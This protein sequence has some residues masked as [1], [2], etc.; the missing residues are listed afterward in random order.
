MTIGQRLRKFGLERYGSI[1]EFAKA[2][3]MSPPG[4][5]QY[6]ADKREPGTPV[7][8]RLIRVGCDVEWLMT[9]KAIAGQATGAV[10]EEGEVYKAGSQGKGARFI[11]RM[12]VTL[13]GKETLDSK[14]FR[15]GAGVP[16]F[17]DTC[18][19]LEV[20]G[21]LLVDAEPIA[22]QPGSICVFE[23]GKQPRLGSVV[24]V[25]LKDG[26]RLVRVVSRSSKVAMGLSA[27]NKYRDYPDVKIKKS[28]IAEM[29]VLAGKIELSEEMKRRFGLKGD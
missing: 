3:Q 27:A 18:F 6:L 20:D 24:A 28:E 12:R 17:M 2:M 11:G 22:I 5:Q 4:L 29:G 9:G 10:R 25:R 26:R 8:Q 19:S 1:K 13:D 15:P 7:L 21:D 23:E 16:F 14:G